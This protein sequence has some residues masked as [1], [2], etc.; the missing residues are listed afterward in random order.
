M[1]TYKLF[2]YI[3][4]FGILVFTSCK[5]EKNEITVISPSNKEELVLSSVYSIGWETNFSGK[6]KIRLYNYMDYVQTIDSA[7]SNN[8]SYLWE[9]PSYLSKDNDYRILVQ[10]LDDPTAYS[11]SKS[12]TIGDGYSDEFTILSPQSG[13]SFQQNKTLPIKWTTSIVPTTISIKLYQN[14]SF[15]QDIVS[16][17]SSDEKEY[18]WFLDNYI[19]VGNNYS[20]I[21]E[22][23]NSNIL[24]ET[25][26]FNIIDADLLTITSP[27]YGDVVYAN[28][29]LQINWG[30]YYDGSSVNIDLYKAGSYQTNIASQYNVYSQYLNWNVSSYLETGD[31]YQI[32]IINSETNETIGTSDYFTISEPADPS[33]YN[34]IIENEYNFLLE[35]DFD[36]NNIGWTEGNQSN[37]DFTISNG[38]YTIDHQDDGYYWVTSVDLAS[39]NSNDNYQVET[40]MKI[41]DDYDAYSHNGMV[42]EADTYY[43]FYAFTFI[44]A[45]SNFA[46][47]HRYNGEWQ[48]NLI[49]DT[50]SSFLNG[51]G[52]YNKITLRKY[53]S[54]FYLFINENFVAEYNSQSPY[55]QNFGLYLEMAKI[56]IDWFT[57]STIGTKKNNTTKIIANKA[58]RGK[59][60]R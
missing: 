52:E 59:I 27:S 60:F 26:Y 25:G 40:Y 28:D 29:Y 10:S 46:M 58:M 18:A 32:Y 9:I 22:D 4:F 11:Y 50:Y 51:V 21:I 13:S 5:K 20:I 57:V 15:L 30:Y 53:D 17:I 45:S 49:N 38:V 3:V 55:G 7:I 16:N 47:L 31:D 33:D 34:G 43:S 48:A 36:N 54:R 6:V 35:E 1:K 24:A 41:I 39:F 14:D 2:L 8:G 19:S 12:F 42:W 56:E 37:I 23:N 44:P